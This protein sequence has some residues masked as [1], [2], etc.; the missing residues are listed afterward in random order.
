MPNTTSRYEPA[1]LLEVTLACELSHHLI[2]SLNDVIQNS[3]VSIQT[4]QFAIRIRLSG[5]SKV[6]C[7][8]EH[9]Q[10]VSET[11]LAEA[12]NFHM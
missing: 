1:A 11:N 6:P 7:T 8:A 9:A 12:P 10:R 4:S 3:I 2:I 5:C